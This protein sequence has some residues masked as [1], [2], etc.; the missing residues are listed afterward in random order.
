L[1]YAHLLPE[2][3]SIGAMPL[4]ETLLNIP[5]SLFVA[6]NLVWTAFT[7]LFSPLFTLLYADFSLILRLLNRCSSQVWQVSPIE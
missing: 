6:I 3:T 2:F 1:V 7:L 4:L 5:Q